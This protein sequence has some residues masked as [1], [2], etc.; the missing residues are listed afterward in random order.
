MAASLAYEQPT[1]NKSWEA[2]LAHIPTI[3]LIWIVTVLL[4]GV[5]FGVSF[6]IALVGLGIG[7]NSG[8]SVVTLSTALAQLGQLP[9]SILSSLVGV[10]FVAVPAMYYHGGE[11]IAVNDAFASLMRRPLRYLLAGVLFSLVAAIGFVLCI[12]P[13]LAVVLVMP[14]YVN[15][16]FLTNQS[17]ADAF[18]ASF[19][20]VYR[21][22][23]GMS[24]L[25]IELLAWL[26]V[27]VVSMCTCGLGALVAVPVSTFYLQ[28]AAYHKG[29]IS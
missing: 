7:G 12:L 22:S 11:T 16:I 13:G 15:R 2:F 23:N 28:N 1:I 29:L 19:R 24:F 17:I 18:A 21:S 25:G 10:L 4:A 26:L 6:V 27:V 20:A 8:D 14:I 3:L 5:G 9:F